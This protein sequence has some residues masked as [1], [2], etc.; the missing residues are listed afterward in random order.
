VRL[1]DEAKERAEGNVAVMARYLI[2]VGL[3][4]SPAA[5]NTI[6]ERHQKPRRL[7]GLALDTE[8]YTRLQ[9]TAAQLELTPTGAARHL[10]RCGLGLD[11]MESLKREET[12]ASLAQALREVREA[13]R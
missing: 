5:A 8:T 10:L 12:F 7:C 13:H 9:G 11:P 2:A 6:E 4:W 1:R 3:G